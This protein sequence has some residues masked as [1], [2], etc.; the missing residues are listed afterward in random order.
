MSRTVWEAIFLLLIL[1]IPIVYLCWVVWYAVKADPKPPPEPAL[2]TAALDLD[3]HDGWRPRFAT[4]RSP[5]RGPHGGPRR[6]YAR[7]S[8]FVRAQRTR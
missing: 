2:K 8:A 1:K 3:P 5:R 7:R 6:T 4:P